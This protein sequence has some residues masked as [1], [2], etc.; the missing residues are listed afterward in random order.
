MYIP[1]IWVELWSPTGFLGRTTKIATHPWALG[2]PWVNRWQPK[3][4]PRVPVW[5]LQC[6][7]MARWMSAP[8]TFRR[9]CGAGGSRNLDMGRI[10]LFF[11]SGCQKDTYIYIHIY[12]ILLLCV[13]HIDFTQYHTKHSDWT[14][15]FIDP[16]NPRKPGVADLQRLGSG[17][18]RQLSDH[19]CWAMFFGDFSTNLV[20]SLKHRK[21]VND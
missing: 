9:S 12:Y 3:R 13:H 20:T 4:P 2:A 14:S 7:E 11:C 16:R 17:G 8:P 18:W 15:R 5:C 1:V 19:R 6:R 10:F 21:S